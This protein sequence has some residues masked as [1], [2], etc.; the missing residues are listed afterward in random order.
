MSYEVLI[1][2]RPLQ[3]ASARRG[4]GT[5]ARG[6]LRGLREE[7]MADRVSLMVDSSLPDPELPG[8]WNL[9]G[10]RR[11]AHGRLHV[12]EDAVATARDLE[13]LRPR[14]YHS[15][16]T[17][18]PVMAPCPVAVTLHD[19]IPWAL[20]GSRLAGERIRYWPAF[21]LLRWADLVIAVSRSSASDGQRLAGVKAERLRVIPE[22][23][24]G[25][26]GERPQARERVRE[27]WGLDPPFLLYAGALDA[28][29][30]PA[31][32]VAAWKVA[33]QTRPGIELVLAGDPGPQAPAEPPGRLLGHVSPEDLADLM[34]TATC[35]LFPS[36]YEGF[37]LPVLEAMACA[38]P[39]VAYSN[40]SLPELV[41]EAGLLVPDG[42]E[43]AL[44]EAVVSLLQDP[45]R[46]AELGAAARARAATFN[47][48]RT[49]RETW[50]AYREVLR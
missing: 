24:E 5:Y 49:A 6:L 29:K 46:A 2:V 34:T 33:R 40:S 32:L 12:Y 19:L 3:G 7:G 26:F 38:C 1:D 27:R 30:D 48:R 45:R 42:D 44:A 35:L 4:I 14:L 18:L 15:L 31:A 13:R 8:S 47:W 21:R 16:Q 36:R 22:S 11:R 9:V 43:S 28:R 41:G 17:S 23:A 50:A 39:V 10:V 20:G 37:G 25:P